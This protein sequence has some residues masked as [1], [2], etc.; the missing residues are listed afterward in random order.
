[1][2]ALFQKRKT[3][4][5]RDDDSE[6]MQKL[7]QWQKHKKI[8][9]DAKLEQQIQEVKPDIDKAE[10]ATMILK[11]KLIQANLKQIYGKKKRLQK[12]LKQQ[13]Q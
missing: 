5:I 10:I 4:L 3:L 13:A 8:C 11:L 9:D 1:M 7:Q 12:K 2:K 6:L